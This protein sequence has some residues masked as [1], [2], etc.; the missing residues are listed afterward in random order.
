MTSPFKILT[1]YLIA[2]AM[3]GIAVMARWLLHPILQHTLI[4][5]TLYGAVAFSA[6]YSGLKPAMLAAIIGYAICNY[7]FIAPGGTFHFDPSQQVGFLAYLFTCGIIIPWVK[8]PDW[9]KCVSCKKK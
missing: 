4:F 3:I 2:M 5:V 1:P 6:W 8:A 9:R 7:L